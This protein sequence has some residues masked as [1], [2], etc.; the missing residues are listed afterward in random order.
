[1]KITRLK[2]SVSALALATSIGAAYAEGE[3]FPPDTDGA[4]LEDD[5]KALTA[6][7]FGKYAKYGPNFLPPDFTSRFGLRPS[8]DRKRDPDR[9]IEGV[10]F[11]LIARSILETDRPIAPQIRDVAGR[12]SSIDIKL[13]SASPISGANNTI[14]GLTCSTQMKLALDQGFEFSWSPLSNASAGIKQALD[15]QSN[16]EARNSVLLMNGTFFS[17]LYLALTSKDTELNARAHSAVFGYLVSSE[18]RANPARSPG[19][20]KS[21][22]GW[23]S[24]VG[25]IRDASTLVI[26]AASG[27]A[28]LFGLEAKL[29]SSARVDYSTKFSSTKFAIILERALDANIDV[30]PL[31]G[32]EQIQ[33]SISAAA[34]FFPK[35]EFTYARNAKI[36]LKVAIRGV[37][38]WLCL[39]QWEA[40]SSDADS[41][42]KVVTE[43][44]TSTGACVMSTSAIVTKDLSKLPI[45]FWNKVRPIADSL[46]Q[47][48]YLKVSH[49]FSTRLFADPRAVRTGEPIVAINKNSTAPSYS[50]DVPFT[51]FPS[52]TTTQAS[53]GVEPKL[54]CDDFAGKAT[55]YPNQI[56]LAGTASQYRLNITVTFDPNSVPTGR[57]ELLADIS[58]TSNAAGI[59]ASFTKQL[60]VVPLIFPSGQ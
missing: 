31:P 18:R 20:L 46:G 25:S 32:Y 16:S 44:N 37:P 60:S 19:Y 47:S 11:D 48:A 52:E 5:I 36:P 1:M 21:I 55:L 26:A 8:L 22:R 27:S 40:S 53:V 7:C 45:E 56:A 24:T 33:A 17:P 49:V 38:D 10:E 29:S 57:C 41:V 30:A 9:L 43:I 35:T 15:F 34:E 23:L 39:N 3:T 4:R 51:V 14:Y 59:P 28:S 6:N 50:I 54:I 13:P 58:F 2:I 12:G 42:D